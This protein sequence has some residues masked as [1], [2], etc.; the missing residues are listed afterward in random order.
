[1]LSRLEIHY[2]PKHGSRLN[3]AEIELSAM[4]VQCLAKQRIPSIEELNQNLFQ[5]YMARNY[6]QKGVDWQFTTDVARVKLKRLY[7]VLSNI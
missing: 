2:T 1:L 5:W 4:A 6:K 3:I 7:P